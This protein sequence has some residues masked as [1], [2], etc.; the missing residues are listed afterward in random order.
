MKQTQQP[1]VEPYFPLQGLG[2]RKQFGERGEPV[3]MARMPA[4]DIIRGLAALWVF[5][6]HASEGRHVDGLVHVLPAS[7]TT[8]LFTAGHLGVPVFFVLS[9]MVIAMSGKRCGESLSQAGHFIARR[10]IRLAPP[11]Y[12]SLIVAAAFLLLKQRFEPVGATLPAPAAIAA[13]LFFL[14]DLL[15]IHAINSVYWTLCIE[16]QFYVAFCVLKLLAHR[17]GRDDACNRSWHSV[18]GIA[19]AVAALWPLGLTADE[20]N[21][22]A[23]FL[24][25]WHLFLLGVLLH[26]ALTPRKACIVPFLVYLVLLAVA[27]TVGRNAFTLGGVA[28]AIVLYGLAHVRNE[29]EPKKFHMLTNLGLISY[30]FYLLHNP[31]T[32]A[33]FSV[34]RRFAG[35]GVAAELFGLAFSLCVCLTAAWLSYIVI[36]RPA[37]RWARRFSS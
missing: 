11:Y 36:E 8:V 23:S 18:M 35:T 31:I 29:A 33:A 5:L 37:I 17:V 3:R 19:C 10:L 24:P 22:H 4:A 27:G 34:A 16:V 15:G 2:A 30:S 13:H 12:L 25:T 7:V 14:Q 26:Q 6:F 32:G 28:T 1:V 21:W 20:T 9:G